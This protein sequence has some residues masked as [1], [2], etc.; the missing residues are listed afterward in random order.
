MEEFLKKQRFRN[1]ERAVK[2]SFTFMETDGLAHQL[3]MHQTSAQ[4]T[5]ERLSEVFENYIHVARESFIK[6]ITQ[7]IE[8]ASSEND[9]IKLMIERENTKVNSNQQLVDKQNKIMKERQKNLLNQYSE[10]EKQFSL[11]ESKY[12][13]AIAQREKQFKDSLFVLTKAKR[14]LKEFQTNISKLKHDTTLFSTTT[15]RDIRT[16]NASARQVSSL[17]LYNWNEKELQKA[18]KEK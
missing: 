8:Q 9:K 17:T 6:K 11:E 18:Q 3:E 5:C 4:F 7:A 15:I 14:D 12:Q 10:V 2:K 1:L 16:L 13:K